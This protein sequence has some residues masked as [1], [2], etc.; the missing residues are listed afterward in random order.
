M[1]GA[2]HQMHIG[3][4]R[5]VKMIQRGIRERLYIPLSRNRCR[6]QIFL[7]REIERFRAGMK[8]PLLQEHTGKAVNRAA[9]QQD[10]G[11]L[12]MAEALHFIDVFIGQIDAAG[13]S[14]F[15]VNH[16]DLAVIAVI[17][18]GIHAGAHGIIENGFDIIAGQFP[19]I[20]GRKPLDTAKII[21]NQADFHT[22][23]GAF[24]QDFQYGIPH[25]AFFNDK[26]FEENELLR[27]RQFLLQ[28]G[29]EVFS[30]GRVFHLGAA[31]GGKAADTANIIGLY[32]ITGKF[33][34]ECFGIPW[35]GGE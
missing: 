29:K 35:L 3:I 31:V 12:P 21:I 8:R 19:G 10:S 1:I 27:L 23:G 25:Q 26:I 30:Q 18:A 2:L 34:E 17:E 33:G 13:K 4:F 9:A 11:I 6:D 32:A 24:F 14:N 20:A 22:G 7:F 5:H 28:P 16:A 15:A